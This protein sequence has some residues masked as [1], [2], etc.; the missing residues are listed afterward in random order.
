MQELGRVLRNCRHG[1]QRGRTPLVLT[2]H[3][4]DALSLIQWLKLTP[5]FMAALYCADHYPDNY[6]SEESYNEK[7]EHF[8]GSLI[9]G[10]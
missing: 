4:P 1:C 6:D 9:H 10:I 8:S 3:E 5:V 7:D 2:S